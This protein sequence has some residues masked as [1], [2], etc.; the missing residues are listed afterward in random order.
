MGLGCDSRTQ[1]KLAS[2]RLLR[3][4]RARLESATISA[5]FSGAAPFGPTRHATPSFMS[6]MALRCLFSPHESDESEVDDQTAAPTTKDPPKKPLSDD[7]TDE[8]APT[9]QTSKQSSGVPGGSGSSSGDVVAP[10][11]IATAA[12]DSDSEDVVESSSV[13]AAG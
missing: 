13:H 10:S 12:S 2:A 8:V 6:A 7:E 1:S 3:F 9:K 11:A 5:Q 4:A